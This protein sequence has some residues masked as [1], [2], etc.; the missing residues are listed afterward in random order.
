M[1]GGFDRPRPV[2]GGAMRV[3]YD[4][5]F[6][7]DLFSISEAV[8]GVGRVIENVARQLVGGGSVNL[9]M[10]GRRG[11]DP[12]PALTSA[13]ARIYWQNRWAQPGCD[14]LETVGSRTGLLRVYSRALARANRLSGG[15]ISLPGILLRKGLNALSRTDAH[16]AS[17]TSQ[18]D[19]FHSSFHP[20]PLESFA[21]PCVLT[22]HDLFPLSEPQGS[23]NRSVTEACLRRLDPA[24]CWLICDSEYTK[25]EFFATVPFPSDRAVVGPLA[26]DTAFHPRP[27]PL[28]CRALLSRLELDDRPFFL[29]VA[30]AQPRKNLA[31][32]VRCFQEFAARDA[33]HHLLLV[34]SR[35]M[36][37]GHE[38]IERQINAVP[39]VSSRI[40]LV[41]PVMDEELAVLYSHCTAFVFPSLAE[42]F[43][44]PPL[45]AMQCGAPVICSNAT[46]LPEVTGDAALQVIPTDFQGIV[47]ALR[48]TA[49]EPTLR[50]ELSGRSLRRAARFSWERTARIVEETYRTAM[51]ASRA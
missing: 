18:C 29:S 24:R 23:Y 17:L 46:S 6:C 20:L 26:A 1:N 48:R 39:G 10:V 34:G 19:L 3:A 33:T 4:V 40:H 7:A 9:R 44:L 38:P 11:G 51:A 2:A 42:G 8:T 16:P 13:R 5:S 47:D 36:G 31:F 25:N 22:L 37:W 21:G 50:A 12:R 49:S 27:D 43:G 32:L 28:D 45:E 35:K 15:E 30:N 14:F 41:G